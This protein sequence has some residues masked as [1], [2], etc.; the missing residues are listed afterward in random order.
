MKCNLHGTLSVVLVND[1]EIAYIDSLQYNELYNYITKENTYMCEENKNKN[2]KPN[3]ETFGRRDGT[4]P[5]PDKTDKK[6]GE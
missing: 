1:N 6:E 3:V 5:R 2:T 4:K